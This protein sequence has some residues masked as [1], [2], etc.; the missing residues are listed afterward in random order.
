MIVSETKEKDEVTIEVATV[1]ITGAGSV[2]TNAVVE[3]GIVPNV[4]IQIFPSAL[5]A[6]AAML[7]SQEAE[8]I[9]EETVEVETAEVET[10]VVVTEEVETAEVE[11][12][13][14]ETA[15]VEIAEVPITEEIGLAPSVRIPI[16]LSAQNAIAVVRLEV[17]VVEET[18]VIVRNAVAAEVEIVAAETAV[19]ETAVVETAEVE[20]VAAETAVVETA[21]VEIVAAETAVVE[22]VEVEIEEVETAEVEIAVVETAEAL[23]VEALAA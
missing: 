6:I 11:I 1:V 21:E 8:E 20:I 3:T 2:E 18:T 7:P 16:S 19:V 4:E 14:V 10:A 13:E 23:H 5:N 22:T 17:E 15:E 12:A 9:V